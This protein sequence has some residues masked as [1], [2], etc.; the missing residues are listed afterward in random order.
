MPLFVTCSL[1]F[2]DCWVGTPP[3]GRRLR[4][5]H[6]DA[7]RCYCMGVSELDELTVALRPVFEKN[8]VL[9]AIAFGSLSRG[10][11]SRRSDLDLLVVQATSKAF[12]DRYDGLL[13]QITRAARRPVDL[14]IYTPSELERLA[15]RPFVRRILNEGRILYESSQEPLP[16]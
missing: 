2:R 14:L 16:G 5:G 15:D 1:L 9:K 6:P 8:H 7:K 13:Q 12:L 11:S 3:A 4:E 10:D